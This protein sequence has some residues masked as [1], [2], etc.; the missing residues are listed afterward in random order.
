[1]VAFDETLY[2]SVIKAWNENTEGVTV[3]TVADRL[4]INPDD[5]KKIIGECRRNGVTM[6]DRRGRKTDP[7]KAAF[8]AEL[9]EES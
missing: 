8:F 4:E 3:E 5:C 6:R 1:M 7:N 9:R 2:R